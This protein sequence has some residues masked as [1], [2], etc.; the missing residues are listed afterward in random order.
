LV[1]AL[2]DLG[3]DAFAQ[4][5]E[6]TNDRWSLARTI[7]DPSMACTATPR[8]T[9]ATGSR[10]ARPA[11]GHAPTNARPE[12]DRTAPVVIRGHAIMQNPNPCHYELGTPRYPGLAIAATFDEL[13]RMV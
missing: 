11:Q 13:A 12:R 3:A 4:P 2:D 5:A 9:P 6:V 10:M 1:V 7:V 8:S